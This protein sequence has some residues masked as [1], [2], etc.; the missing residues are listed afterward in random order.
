MTYDNLF[1]GLPCDIFAN[2]LPPYY[3][4]YNGYV[5]YAPPTINDCG[6]SLPSPPPPEPPCPVIG[7]ESTIVASSFAPST[8]PILTRLKIRKTDCCDFEISVNNTVPCVQLGG[9]VGYVAPFTDGPSELSIEVHRVE[10]TLDPAYTGGYYGYLY[11]DCAF[12]IHGKLTAH[13]PTISWVADQVPLYF[14]P[15]DAGYLSLYSTRDDENC[16]FEL[17]VAGTL[18]CAKITST[19]QATPL[20]VPFALGTPGTA[21][22]KVNSLSNCERSL[23]ITL[24]DHLPNITSKLTITAGAVGSSPSGTFD[25]D[26][27]DTT[28][29]YAANLS[30][31]IPD[32]GP[33]FPGELW[34]VI[35]GHL[36]KK[37]ETKCTDFTVGC[38]CPTLKCAEPDEDTGVDCDPP[39]GKHGDATD[40]PDDPRLCLYSWVRKSSYLDDTPCDYDAGSDPDGSQLLGWRLCNMHPVRPDFEP[41]ACGYLPTAATITSKIATMPAKEVNGIKTVVP[42]TIVRLVLQK[43]P[44]VPELNHYLFL[45]PRIPVDEGNAGCLQLV[46]DSICDLKSGFATNKYNVYFPASL[47]VQIWPAGDDSPCLNCAAVD[48]PRAQAGVYGV[49]TTTIVDGA[50]VNSVLD[51]PPA[52]GC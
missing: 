18:P 50:P 23:E 26:R 39:A 14:S 36:C 47:G 35:T 48:G 31:S 19:T 41:P 33:A 37:T 5:A 52:A 3:A 29:N 27:N 8:S 34:A 7:P 10:R 13:C 45:A 20:T 28:G 1:Y 2:N 16:N 17:R 9:Y 32:C 4:I 38:D 22:L 24:T 15:D 42:G 46:T 44:T 30:L 25:I 11:D 6:I 12:E 43:H 49:I 51:P 40:Y 21:Q